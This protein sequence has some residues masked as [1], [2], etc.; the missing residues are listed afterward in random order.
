MKIGALL[1]KGFTLRQ[2]NSG[3]LRGKV[4]VSFIY[5]HRELMNVRAGVGYVYN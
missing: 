1:I 4:S 3:T 2:Q 5:V